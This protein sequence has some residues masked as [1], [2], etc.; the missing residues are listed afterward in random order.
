LMSLVGAGIRV[1]NSPKAI[2]AAVDKFLTLARLQAAGVPVPE[3]RVSQT[4]R[5]AKQHYEQLGGNVVVKPIFG[6]L[7]RDIFQIESMA[8]AIPYFDH[9]ESTGRVIYQQQAIDHGGSDIRLL[10]IGDRVWGMRRQSEHWITNI[11]QGGQGHP[12][13][14]NEVERELALCA[15]KYLGAEIAGVDLA[16]D[17]NSNQP[18][19]LEVNSSPGWRTFGKVCDVDVASEIIEYLGYT[20]PSPESR[21]RCKQD[22]PSM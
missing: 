12:H 19:V 18:I 11:R 16:Y 20:P 21:V 15:S 10:V 14:P 8:E 1:V 4:A 9:C 3:T 13:Q 2:E 6:S 17:R 7:G 5:T 22:P